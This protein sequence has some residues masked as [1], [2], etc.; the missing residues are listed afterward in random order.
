VAAASALLGEG[1]A[2]RFGVLFRPLPPSSIAM[3]LLL[4]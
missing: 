3:V 1:A 4:A 2:P